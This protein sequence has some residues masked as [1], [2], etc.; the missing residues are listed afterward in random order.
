MSVRIITY[1]TAD[2]D[3]PAGMVWA[4]AMVPILRPGKT[5]KDKDPFVPG[6]QWL[7][8]GATEAEARGKLEA[9]WAA[10]Y[11]ERKPRAK[12]V[13]PDDDIDIVL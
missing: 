13:Q 3:A 4:A 6:S 2:P 11:P 12:A 7:A 10:Q 5:A 8:T 9:M 1:V